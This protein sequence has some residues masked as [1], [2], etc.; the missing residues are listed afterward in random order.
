MDADPVGQQIEVAARFVS[1]LIVLADAGVI[2]PPSFQAPGYGEAVT[3][4]GTL[5][6]TAGGDGWDGTPGPARRMAEFA[7]QADRELQRAGLRGELMDA[8]A[9]AVRGI[10]A[11]AMA[12]ALPSA[13]MVHQ[14]FEVKIPYDSLV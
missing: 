11:R 4:V 9:S 14:P 5:I 7:Q 6:Q 12:G 8:A 10:L 3:Q 1:R 2:Y 13:R